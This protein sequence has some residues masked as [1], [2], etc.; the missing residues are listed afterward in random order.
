MLNKKII[1]MEARGLFIDRAFPAIAVMF[2]ALLVYGFFNAA[3]WMK[4]RGSQSQTIVQTQDQEIEDRRTKV[5]A[6]EKGSNE[7]GNFKADPGDPYDIGVSLQHAVLPFVP[8]AIFAVGQSDIL[9]LDLG[10][11]LLTP[12]RTKADKVGFENPLSFLYGK[13]DSAF[14][15]VYLL[16]LLILAFSF[17]LLSSERELGT[18]QLV[19][20]QPISL[21][22][23]M[24][25]KM[26]AQFLVIAGILLIS[27]IAGIIVTGSY[28]SN[29]ELVIRSLF[30]L[31][32]VFCYAAFWLS[33]AIFI[34][35]FG[36]GSATNAVASVTAWL[37][38]VLVIPSVLAIAVSALYPLPPRSEVTSAIRN[39]N[40]D[41]RRDGQKLISEYYQDH[42]ELMPADGKIDAAD[43]GLAFVYIQ[44]EHKKKIAEIETRFDEQLRHQQDLVSMTRF[45][46]PAIVTNEALNDLAGTGL[47]RYALFRHQAKQFDSDWS[48]YFRSKIFRNEPVT[49]EDFDRFPRFEFQEPPTIEYLTRAGIGIAGIFVFTLALLIAAIARLKKLRGF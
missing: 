3:A 48:A 28:L 20:S 30:W 44:S 6:G 47:S 36:Y 49:L 21:V 32:L 5:A 8:A 19:L 37:S 40:L 15:V 26:T 31:L 1:K 24:M 11:S 2:A 41:M 25:S 45:L 14:V 33:V 29:G 18:L 43:F 13:F 38:F 22:E 27:L 7:P 12:Q 17:N 35:S 42:P 39:I 46:S 16:P 4:V 23:M 10:A 34:N 9:P